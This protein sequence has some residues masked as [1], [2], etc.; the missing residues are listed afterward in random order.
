MNM[1]DILINTEDEE[2]EDSEEEKRREEKWTCISFGGKCVNVRR[3]T[4]GR[5]GWDGMGRANL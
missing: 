3:M 4:K 5:L 2:E 1:T